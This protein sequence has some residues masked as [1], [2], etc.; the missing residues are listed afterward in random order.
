[1]TTLNEEQ[2]LKTLGI[3]SW[4]NLSKDKFLKYVTMVPDV[5]ENVRLKVLD[6]L[7]GIMGFTK[8]F[9]QTIISEQRDITQKNS[10]TTNIIIHSLEAI[11]SSID[12][13][14]KQPNITFEQR[15]YFCGIQV[16]IAQIY[17]ELDEHNKKFL[18]DIWDGVVKFG[19]TVLG[20]VV[21][22]LGGKFLIS[23]QDDKN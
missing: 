13:L 22:V 21:L 1:M 9:V 6:Q 7:P 4:R 19:I 15:Q 5:S 2:A 14:S 17:L 20:F 18:S 10:E 16:E 23:N 12:Q 3:D 11:Q 8:E